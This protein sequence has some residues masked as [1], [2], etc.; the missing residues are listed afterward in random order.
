V[1]KW[2]GGGGGDVNMII[3]T[4]VRI[5]IHSVVTANQSLYSGR[6]PHKAPGRSGKSFILLLFFFF[7]FLRQ[8]LRYP[9]LSISSI[10]S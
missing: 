7:F 5:T 10:C 8:G 9:K 6:H 4:C 2:G 3:N 1:E